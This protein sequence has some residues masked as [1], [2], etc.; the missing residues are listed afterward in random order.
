MQKNGFAEF[1]VSFVTYFFSSL[2]TSSCINNFFYR[3][4]LIPLSSFFSLHRFFL[5]LHHHHLPSHHNTVHISHSATHALSPPLP[6]I[7]SFLP[8]HPFSPPLPHSP[9]HSSLCLNALPLCFHPTFSFFIRSLYSS[10]YVLSPQ[11]RNCFTFI[12]I[13]Y[14]HNVTSLYQPLGSVVFVSCI[15]IPYSSL[16]FLI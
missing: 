1:R 6:L 3:L 2:R 4:L 13:L 14:S 11:G 8:P 10:Q 12:K 15:S 7:F 5:T 16:V 9:S